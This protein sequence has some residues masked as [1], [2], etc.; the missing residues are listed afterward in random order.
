MELMRRFEGGPLRKQN[1]AV[2]I[3]DRYGPEVEGLLEG[4]NKLITNSASFLKKLEGKLKKC[5]KQREKL[6]KV[7]ILYRK[8]IDNKELLSL[9][10]S[11]I[12][13]IMSKRQNVASISLELVGFIEPIGELYPQV[14]TEELSYLH[15]FLKRESSSNGG[16][17]NYSNGYTFNIVYGVPSFDENAFLN[18]IK[19]SKAAIDF[20]ESRNSSGQYKSGVKWEMKIGLSY[21]PGVTGTIGDSYVVIGGVIDNSRKMLE[22]AK[23]YGVSLVSDSEAEIRRNSRVKYRKL[24][25]VNTGHDTLP[26]AYVYEIFLKEDHRTDNAIKLFN[27]GLEM[28]FEGRYDVALYDFKKVKKLLGEDNPSDIFLERCDRMIKGSS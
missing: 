11:T 8:Y 13:D 6:K 14:I 19:G 2:D 24:D 23:F 9:S 26:E 16:M 5:L 3:T 1:V 10:E 28:F 25:L 18:A 22:H 17:I 27:H 20:V 4:Y 12:S 21:G 7:I 15:S